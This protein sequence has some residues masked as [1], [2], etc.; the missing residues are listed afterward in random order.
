MSESYLTSLILRLRQ[1]RG[2]SDETTECFNGLREEAA[3]TIEHLRK[4]FD[5]N[6]RVVDFAA[7]S[8]VSGAEYMRRA[9]DAKDAGRAL[10]DAALPFVKIVATTSGRIPTERLSFSDWHALCSAWNTAT[11]LLSEDGREFGTPGDEGV[12][13][14]QMPKETKRA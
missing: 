8:L 10:Y 14:I 3:S 12:Q 9:K 7:R 5:D 13:A 4:E 1:F 2:T 11:P 6:K